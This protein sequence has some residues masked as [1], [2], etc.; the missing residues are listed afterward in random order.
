MFISLFYQPIQYQ[1]TATNLFETI[2]DNFK[3]AVSGIGPKI[4][5]YSAHD[6]TVGMVLAAFNLTNVACINDKYIKDLPN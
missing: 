5:L 4:I 6:T 3:A 1:T 2:V